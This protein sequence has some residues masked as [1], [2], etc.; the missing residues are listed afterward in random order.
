[1]SSHIP[2][3]G[4]PP[5]PSRPVRPAPPPRKGLHGCL[6]ALIVVACLA[7]PAVAILAAIA[8]PAYNDYLA[9]SRVAQSVA[10]TA[11]LQRAVATFVEGHR[12][13]PVNGDPGFE[14]AATYRGP[15]HASI[16]FGESDAG[17]CAIEMLLQDDRHETVDGY[18]LWLEYDTDTGVWHCS[19]EAEDRYLPTH[20]RG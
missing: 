18:R 17:V 20:C 11:P 13:C 7:I 3:A 9:R 16:V 1:M 19:S 15:A 6:I 12:R 14:A 5:L 10:A 4:P 8:I 2:G